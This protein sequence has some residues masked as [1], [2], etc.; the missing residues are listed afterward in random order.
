MPAGPSSGGLNE[1]SGRFVPPVLRPMRGP[2]PSGG[3]TNWVYSASWGAWVWL[4]LRQ[5]FSDFS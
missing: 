4:Y 1:N 5:G 3:A 2:L